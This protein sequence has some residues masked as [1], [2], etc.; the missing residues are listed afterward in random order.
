M[1]KIVSNATKTADGSWRF[2]YLTASGKR[3]ILP[4]PLPRRG[5]MPALETTMDTKKKTDTLRRLRNVAGHVNGVAKMVEQDEYCID[6]IA[7][8]QAIDAALNK[9]AAQILDDH[10]HT[11]VIKAV[12]GSNVAERERVLAE[13]A[14][15]FE[16][17][18]K[19]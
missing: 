7:Q 17:A 2:F 16:T 1:L 11:C 3:D 8:I 19:V 4:P 14:E 18:T 6:V 15:V 12:R 13:I 10:L 9:V 5:G